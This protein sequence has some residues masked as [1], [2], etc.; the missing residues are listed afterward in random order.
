MKLQNSQNRIEKLSLYDFL[1]IHGSL[2]K[3][4]KRCTQKP[5]SKLKNNGNRKSYS[6]L[7]KLPN[8]GEKNMGENISPKTKKKI[9]K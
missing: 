2:C 4:L 1:A 6:D 9:Q 5:I 7:A 8:V 3:L